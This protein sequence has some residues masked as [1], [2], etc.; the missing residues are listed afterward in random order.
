MSRKMFIKSIFIFLG[1]FLNFIFGAAWWEDSNF[2]LW[3]VLLVIELGSEYL[4][5]CLISLTYVNYSFK[6]TGELQCG[7]EVVEKVL[8]RK[9]VMFPIWKC[10]F[11][12]PSGLDI[13]SRSVPSSSLAEKCLL[14]R[15]VYELQGILIN[16]NSTDV[17]EKFLP[18]K[19]CNKEFTFSAAGLS[20][21]D[22]LCDMRSVL[23]EADWG[24]GPLVLAILQMPTPLVSYQWYR[25]ISLDCRS[26][27]EF[28][29]L[30]LSPL[31]WKHFNDSKL[32]GIVLKRKCLREGKAP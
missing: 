24:Q 5:I 12:M 23:C 4:S 9:P 15:R 2:L 22:L 11:L 30:L 31:K 14:H 19:F 16:T 1:C 26:L 3:L 17:W 28:I 6:K 13:S 27:Q 29:I 8:K 10:T 18:S 7:Q 25:S 20:G 32:T 21:N